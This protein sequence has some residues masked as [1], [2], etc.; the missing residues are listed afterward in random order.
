MTEQTIPLEAAQKRRIPLLDILRGTA[1]IAMASYHF[2][3][4]LGDFGYIDP[5]YP[6]TGWPKIYAR[7][8]ASTFLFLAGLSMVLGH[9]QGFRTRAYL[10]RL[11]K[12]VAAAALVSL[13]S[14]LAM[15]QG[16]IFF[17][18]LHSIAAMSVIGLLFLRLPGW[19][20][21][22]LAALAFLAPRYFASESFNT[23][24][25]WWVGLSTETRLS[26]DYVPILPWLCPFLLGM[27]LG[28]S[29]TA[30]AALRHFA[31]GIS[32]KNPVNRLLVFFG[33]HSLTFYLV[34]QP[35]LIALLW[36]FSQIVPA[37]PAD[38]VASYL[39]SCV[40]GCS[41]EQDKALCQVF[42][43]CTLEELQA[44]NLFSAFQS[45]AISAKH[46]ERIKAIAVQC[47]VPAL[48]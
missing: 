15:P 9:E 14:A 6:A 33:R 12:I 3:W 31:Q 30:M 19:V 10:I 38:P 28:Q 17:G 7:C 44:Q 43:Q 47:S 26:F 23:P 22:I 5:S 41:K 35:V 27:A 45:G 29:S 13:A 21:I 8:I 20:N 1:L 37:P 34:H 40:A 16:L 48:E 2:L 42:C 46:D 36:I 32:G 18:I 24:W 4:D 39:E 11:G 25:L